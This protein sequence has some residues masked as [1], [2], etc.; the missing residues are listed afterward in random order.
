MSSKFRGH[1]RPYLTLRCIQL[2]NQFRGFCCHIFFMMIIIRICLF[3]D[4]IVEGSA[5]LWTRGFQPHT[6]RA[7]AAHYPIE[8]ATESF[9]RTFIFCDT[10]Q[11]TYPF[12]NFLKGSAENIIQ[13]EWKCQRRINQS[14]RIKM[15]HQLMMERING[16]IFHKK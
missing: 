6:L 14:S 9:C 16:T 7:K 10:I 5:P 3:T 4:V 8:G 1:F 11:P 2:F 15:Q 13:K 12:R